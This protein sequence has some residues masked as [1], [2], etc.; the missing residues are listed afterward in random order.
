MHFMVVEDGAIEDIFQTCLKMTDEICIEQDGIV[1]FADNVAILL[2]DNMVERQCS[3]FVRTEHIHRS[4]ILNRIQP[5]NDDLF[6]GHEYRATGETDGDQSS[7]AS[8][9]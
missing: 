9:A 5:F 8:P 4:K 7:A 3:G 2:Q 6:L 1:L